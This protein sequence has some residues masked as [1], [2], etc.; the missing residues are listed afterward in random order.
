MSDSAFV[1]TNVL[2]YARDS[3]EPKKQA[4]A[5]DLLKE[6][7]ET[8]GGRISTQVCSEYFV[9]VTQKL[10]PGLSKEE[11]WEDIEDLAAWNPA[12]VNM[13]VLREARQIQK[14]YD[15]SWW[16][17]LILSAALFTNCR[18][19]YSEDLDS[20]STYSGVKVINPFL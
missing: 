6:L 3:S 17:S 7:W 15:I 18:C 9:T 13:Q 19:I 8:G 20:G 1:D 4:L 5:M 16:D 11:A 10:T 12:P 2:V 14:R